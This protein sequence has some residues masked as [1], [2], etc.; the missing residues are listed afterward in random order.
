MADPKRIAGLLGPSLVAIG[1]SEGVNLEIWRA[2][3]PPTVYFS[4]ALLFIAGLA[5]VRVHNR[6]TFAWPTLITVVGWLCLLGGLLRMFAPRLVQPGTSAPGLVL[7]FLG[8][9]VAVG[10]FLSLKALRP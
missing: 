4:G 7:S 6:W 10:L 5:I 8:V 3:S 1:L 9:T 2:V